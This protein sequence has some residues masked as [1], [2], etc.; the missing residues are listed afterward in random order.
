LRGIVQVSS[1]RLRLDVD[2]QQCR[3]PRSRKRCSR[4]SRR[5]LL[6][7]HGSR[8][9]E[10]P[11][12]GVTS[13]TPHRAGSSA[14]EPGRN[15]PPNSPAAD[16]TGRDLG[17][18]LSSQ[19]EGDG[20]VV[21]CF[22]SAVH[23]AGARPHG[24]SDKCPINLASSFKQAVCW[25]GWSARGGHCILKPSVRKGHS[26]WL[27]RSVQVEVACHDYWTFSVVASRV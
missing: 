16:G 13:S 18:G 7:R 22:D 1:V 21:R 9:G 15:H 2:L 3:A 14:Q 11:G 12:F 19:H 10:L 17:Q 24:S 26:Y 5:R 23:L 20:V 4:S 8:R 27:S 25:S 6:R